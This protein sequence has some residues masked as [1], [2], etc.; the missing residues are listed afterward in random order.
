[1]SEVAKYDWKQLE[2]DYILGDY[3]S[4]SSFLKDK[5]IKQNG[6]T[7]KSTKGWKEKKVLKEDKKSTKVIE[8]VLEKESEKEANKI[9]KVKDVANDL[10][11]KIVQANNE[12]NMHIA[13]NKKK[14]KTVEYDYKCNKPSRE[15]INEEE[16]IK[17][18]I[19]I[20]DRK[21][22]KELTSALKDL[23]DILDPKEDD[24]EEDNSFIEA[25]NNKTEDIWSEEEK[26][27]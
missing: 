25:L 22:L 6:S 15:V 1:V 7:K 26:Q 21:G 27:S 14:T 8:K 9:I 18:Y 19:D 24:E 17:S 20:I 5:G 2:K 12:L 23:N 13:R 16:E 10:L 3:K 11:S 4:V